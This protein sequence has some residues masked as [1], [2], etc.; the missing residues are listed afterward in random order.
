MKILRTQR[1]L[2]RFQSILYGIGV[3][4][5]KSGLVLA[6][7]Q[8]AAIVG[9]DAFRSLS[10]FVLQYGLFFPIRQ[11]MK[12]VNSRRKKVTIVDPSK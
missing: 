2:S 8:A 4:R 10:R 11:M 9:I 7:L 3:R 5:Q 6:T 12:L 1:G